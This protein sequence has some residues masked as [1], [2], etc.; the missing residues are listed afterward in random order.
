MNKISVTHNLEISLYVFV[1]MHFQLFKFNKY[2]ML[3]LDGS[4]GLNSVNYRKSV[5]FLHIYRC[6]I[7]KSLQGFSTFIFTVSCFFF[8]VVVSCH[9]SLF[10]TTLIIKK[11]ALI[12][13]SAEA[14]SWAEPGTPWHL[15][16]C[17][18][19]RSG[20]ERAGTA[21]THKRENRTTIYQYTIFIWC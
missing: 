1:K 11:K 13:V 4:Y 5:F 19:H 20:P 8:C 10:L 16:L 3:Y 18:R 17:Q 14:Y 12:P 2:M 9:F 6:D 21:E 15:W 7:L